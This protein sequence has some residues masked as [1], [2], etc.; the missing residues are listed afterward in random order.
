MILKGIESMGGKNS[1]KNQ[2][3]QGK[4]CI[5]IRKFGQQILYVGEAEN[6]T[7]HQYS[8]VAQKIRR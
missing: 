6:I 8:N 4:E 2:K 1:L 3:N 7:S 5:N